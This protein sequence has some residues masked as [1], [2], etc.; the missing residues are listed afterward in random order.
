LLFTLDLNRKM[1]SLR[2]L[3]VTTRFIQ[4]TINRHISASPVAKKKLH[5]LGE[6]QILFNCQTPKVDLLFTTLHTQ[7]RIDTTSDIS[8]HADTIISG[9][10]S[11]FVSLM[12]S[13][14]SIATLLE[15]DSISVQG[16]T[17]LLE[18]LTS[19]FTLSTQ[20][21]ETHLSTYLGDIPAHLLCRSQRSLI[22]KTHHARDVF[23]Q[24]LQHYFI[25]EIKIS[26][27]S[28]E[29]SL[30]SNQVLTLKQDAE[31]LNER[32]KRLSY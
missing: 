22:K 1:L 27:S 30:F 21:L 29:V 5:S 15:S 25:D 19:L 23:K 6:K 4:K 14:I 7:I 28:Y 9:S 31:R 13:K 8:T 12:L 32:I 20:S 3:P 26:P 11:H 17:L 2:P 10:L 18:Q 16:N 24:T